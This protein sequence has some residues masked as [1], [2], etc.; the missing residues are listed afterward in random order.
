MPQPI[1]TVSHLPETPDDISLLSDT[2]NSDL[3]SSQIYSPTPSQIASNPFNPP[4][5]PV[6][7]VERLLSQAH[8]SHSFNIVYSSPSFQT[9][10]PLSFTGTPPIITLSSNSATP[11]PDPPDPDPT[12]SPLYW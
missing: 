6:T 4:Q 8:W 9:S 5:G 2:S 12:P 1:Y 11:D 7:N 10:I 3:L